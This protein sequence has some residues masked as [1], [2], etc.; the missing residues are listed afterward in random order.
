[1]KTDYKIEIESVRMQVALSCF[2]V[3]FFCKETE[4]CPKKTHVTVDDKICKT[5]L[6]RDR[7]PNDKPYVDTP[8][9]STRVHLQTRGTHRK[10]LVVFQIRG[11]TCCRRWTFAWWRTPSAENGTRVRAN[12]SAWKRSKCARDGKTEG[13]ILAG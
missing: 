6:C 10:C 13:R 4:N 8:R 11:R 1:M 3:I 7:V 12:R 2:T 5:S 9:R